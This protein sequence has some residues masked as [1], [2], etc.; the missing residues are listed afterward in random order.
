[1]T[2]RDAAFEAALPDHVLERMAIEAGIADAV[3][4]CLL[5]Y[6][7]AI[8]DAREEADARKMESIDCAHK[9]GIGHECAK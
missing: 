9:C 7:R 1:M 6:A 5:R 4:G 2:E 3:P 8:W